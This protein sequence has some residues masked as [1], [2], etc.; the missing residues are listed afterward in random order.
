[1]RI[2]K[3]RFKDKTR[4]KDNDSKE[5][6]ILFGVVSPLP[7]L[8]DFPR[9]F[10]PLAM[11]IRI[12]RPCILA[13]LNNAIQSFSMPVCYIDLILRVY[14]DS[15]SFVVLHL[16]INLVKSNQNQIKSNA[17]IFLRN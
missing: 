1:M 3:Y 12:E 10:F 2:F 14:F 8:G 17:S 16:S 6:R 13:D 7:Y 5:I 15:L 4:V 9:I 11:M